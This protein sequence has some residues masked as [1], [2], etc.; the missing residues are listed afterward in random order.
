MKRIYIVR[1]VSEVGKT[2]ILN[3]LINWLL[4]NFNQTNTIKSERYPPD[5]YGVIEINNF[6]IGIITQGDEYN[7]VKMRLSEMDNEN[8]DVIICACRTRLSSYTAVREF[9]DTQNTN[10]LVYLSKW[11]NLQAPF[12]LQQSQRVLLELQTFLRGI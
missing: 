7:H 1:G 6:R 2:T 4:T 8:C 5:R 10:S 11:F 9:L 3:N 12:N